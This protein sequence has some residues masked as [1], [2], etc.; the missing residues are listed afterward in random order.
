MGDMPNLS[1]SK[2]ELREAVRSLS[3]GV[4]KKAGEKDAQ[5]DWKSDFMT[6]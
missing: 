5:G 1:W 6:T 2:G 3:L 4:L